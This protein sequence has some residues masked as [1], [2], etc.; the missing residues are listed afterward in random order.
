MAAERRIADATSGRRKP[1]QIYPTFESAFASPEL[2]VDVVEP[3][4][5]Q[6]SPSQNEVSVDL[7]TDLMPCTR[8]DSDAS[9]PKAASSK[10]VSRRSAW[11]SLHS[12]C[13]FRDVQEDESIPQ[14]G[15][16]RFHITEFPIIETTMREVK[17]VSE[18][19]YKRRMYKRTSELSTH[20][21]QNRIEELGKL[22][23]FLFGFA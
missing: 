4:L 21:F 22:V 18:G 5:W 23:F 2:S 17:T 6:T 8:R 19:C 15:V 16:T 20:G 1:H 14:P 3:T 10:P 9:H 11:G 12:Y 7:W 13:F